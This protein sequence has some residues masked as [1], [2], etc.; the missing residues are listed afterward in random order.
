MAMQCQDVESAQ[1]P[2]LVCASCC[3]AV[4]W[5]AREMVDDYVVVEVL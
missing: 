5:F 2:F 4:C 1:M 3:Q